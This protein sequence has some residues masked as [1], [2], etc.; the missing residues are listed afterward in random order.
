MDLE[1]WS[2]EMSVICPGCGIRASKS[3]SLISCIEWCKSAR[4]CVGDTRYNEYFNQK[5]AMMKETR[6]IASGTSAKKEE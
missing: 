6:E 5:S 4:G 2:D 3:Q 1:Q